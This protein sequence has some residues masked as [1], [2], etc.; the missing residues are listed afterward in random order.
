MK[1]RNIIYLA[2]ALLFTVSAAHAMRWGAEFTGVSRRTE[3]T[4]LAK[5]LQY[6]TSNGTGGELD[7]TNRLGGSAAFFIEG[8]S[9]WSLGAAAGFG[10]MPGTAYTTWSP[11]YLN[12][13]DQGVL[14]TRTRYIPVDLYIKYKPENSKFSLFGGAGADYIMASAEVN[15]NLDG[16]G[17]PQANNHKGRFTQK[18]V[19][20][21]VRAGAEWFMFKWLSLN[22]SAKYLFSAV[23]DKLTGELTGPGVSAGKQI[24][25][26]SQTAAG[27]KLG[28]SPASAPLAP[29]AR[30]LKY[31]FSGLRLNA[32]LRFYFN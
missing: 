15:D 29:G 16:S 24:L 7:D 11:S 20:P 13:M 2:A 12:F 32:A 14:E 18:K 8:R 4:D 17:N 27:E 5:D 25:T 3:A 21:H 23:F 26:M 22:V 10:N 19:A 30:P 1:N 28:F 9:K 6:R 31:D